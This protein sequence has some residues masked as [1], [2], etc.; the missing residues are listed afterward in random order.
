MEQEA[1]ALS[2]SFLSSFLGRKKV[3]KAD[4]AR[5]EIQ[6]LK[7]AILNRYN[8]NGKDISDDETKILN[9]YK[10]NPSDRMHPT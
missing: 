8:G 4:T 2:T 7:I 9:T 6:Q 3:K 10:P 1:E 5:A